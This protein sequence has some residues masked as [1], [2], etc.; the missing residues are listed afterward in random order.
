MTCRSIYSL[1]GLGALFALQL[2][3]SCDSDVRV[4]DDHPVEHVYAPPP[5]PPQEVHVY[6]EGPPTV[7]H[8]D[9]RVYEDH[10]RGH[11]DHYDDRPVPHGIPRG[12]YVVEDKEGKIRWTA[13]DNG[14]FYV[15]DI[16]KEFV[17]YSGT[18][19]RG[20][21][22]IVQPGDDIVYVD[23]RAVTHENLRRDARHQI[24]FAPGVRDTQTEEYRGEGRKV[25]G[26]ADPG[27]TIPKD[28]SRFTSGRGDLVINAAKKGGKVFVYDED[29]RNVI[30]TADI[31]RGNSFKYD[32]DKGFIY[33]NSKRIAAVKV[34]RGH[35]LSLYFDE[36]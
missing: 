29:N 20:Q 26:A 24:Y 10:D 22:V 11:Y 1:L 35:T 14:T 28:A 33:V 9:V 15:Y 32:A 36:H 23:Q 34:P 25:G 21:E 8:E 4:H 30:Y 6:R 5:P 17:R 12:F 3:G 31:D 27:R 2:G 7:V 18:V 19:H 16:S 13:P